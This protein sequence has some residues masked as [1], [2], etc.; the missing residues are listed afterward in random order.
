MNFQEI[1]Q[2]AEENVTIYMPPK[3]PRDPEKYGDQRTAREADSKA[4]NAWRKQMG[5]DEAKEIY[6]Q[7]AA[8][9]E[10]VNADLK[11]HRGL[12]Q[13]TVRSLPKA[14]CV[15]LWCVLAYNLMHMGSH[16]G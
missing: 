8:T 15:A 14:R 6:K 11:T 5:S 2:S 13:L 7:R 12:T 1:E 4:V 16:L 9:S 3:P 10:R